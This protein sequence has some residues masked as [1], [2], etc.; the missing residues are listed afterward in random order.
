MDASE[1]SV[2]ARKLRTYYLSQHS[3]Q[4]RARA[5]LRQ[6]EVTITETTNSKDHGYVKSFT[7]VVLMGLAVVFTELS[8]RL[9]K[10]AK[11]LEMA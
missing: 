6:R 4:A 3:P 11:K 7:M 5:K 9:I 10:W 2:I 1:S 8:L